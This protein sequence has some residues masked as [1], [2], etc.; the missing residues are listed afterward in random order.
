[1]RSHPNLPLPTQLPPPDQKLGFLRIKIVGYN[2]GDNSLVLAQEHSC[3]QSIIYGLLEANF[4]K[5][6]SAC[7]VGFED[8]K[9]DMPEC[10]TLRVILFSA[11]KKGSKEWIPKQLTW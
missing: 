9:S 11:I 7:M 6:D 4:R 5:A 1:M 2:C 10:I 8:N 3:P